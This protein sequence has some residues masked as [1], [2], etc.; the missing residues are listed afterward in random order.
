MKLDVFEALQ[1]SQP[2]ELGTA[3][4]LTSKTGKTYDARKLMVTPELENYL[5]EYETAILSREHRE[6][7]MVVKPRKWTSI[8]EGGYAYDLSHFPTNIFMRQRL[9]TNNPFMKAYAKRLRSGRTDM[10]ALYDSVNAI[11]ETPFEINQDILR[12]MESIMQTRGDCYGFPLLCREEL[13]DRCPEDATEEEKE[14]R[15]KQAAIIHEREGRRKVQVLKIKSMLHRARTYASY[16]RLYFPHNIDYRGRVYPMTV[17]IHPQGDDKVKSLLLFAEPKAITN[18]EEGLYYLALVGATHS[19][20]L[21]EDGRTLSKV[22]FDTRY[23]W[24]L[25]HTP[26]IIEAADNPLPEYDTAWWWEVSQDEHPWNFLAFCF[27]WKYAHEWIEE[28][29]TLVGFKP[30]VSLPFDGSCSGLQHYSA[31]LKDKVGGRTVNLTPNKEVGDVY[32]ETAKHVTD[33]LVRITKHGYPEIL[34]NKKLTDEQRL[35]ALEGH[36]RTAEMWLAYN[37]EKSGDIKTPRKVCKR[38]TMTL[39]YGS[40]RAGFEDHIR[41]DIVRPYIEENKNNDYK[42]VFYTGDKENPFAEYE[43]CFLM[44]FVMDEALDMVVGLPKDAMKLLQKLATIAS[45][46]QNAISWTTPV[47]LEVCQQKTIVDYK[48]VRVSVRG[49]KVKRLS[50]QV[51]HKTSTLDSNSQ[52]N[53]IAPN[54]IHS[55]DAAHLQLVVLGAQKEGITNFMLIH[56]SFGTDIESSARF[57]RIIREQFVVLYGSNRDYIG[58]IMDSVL[59]RIM[60]TDVEYTPENRFDKVNYDSKDFKFVKDVHKLYDKIRL[61]GDRKNHPETILDISGILESEFAFA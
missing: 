56:D 51:P 33:I 50:H 25:E 15:N 47:G 37:V 16:Q 8:D 17:D 3:K 53:S 5:A 20:A 45:R 2:L 36:R 43:A 40:K 27:E 30:K 55:M 14:R 28:H 41:E 21:M 24:I 22:N 54:F 31:M 12:V 61:D 35:E 23:K 6:C 59:S 7:P 32:S 29:G 52:R 58:E 57:F 13:P 42:G 44:S 4:D 1:K 46:N 10:S 48:A 39:V 38:C 18:H 26:Q 34:K 19:D 9:A 60:V 11:Q 49:L